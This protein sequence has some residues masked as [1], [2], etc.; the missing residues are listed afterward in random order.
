VHPLKDKHISQ[1]SCGGNFA[2]GLGQTLKNHGEIGGPLPLHTDSSLEY[3]KKQET[4]KDT[5]N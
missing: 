2:I 4:E 5:F 1:L 3:H